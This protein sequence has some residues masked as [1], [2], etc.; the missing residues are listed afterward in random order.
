MTADQSAFTIGE[1]CARNGFSKATYYN[2]RK[3]DRPVEMLIGDKLKRIT[4]ESEADWH[5][6]M[7]A[8]AAKE[9]RRA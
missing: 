4:P 7:E 3:A 1:F 8:R 5:R 6:R 2:L 9:D